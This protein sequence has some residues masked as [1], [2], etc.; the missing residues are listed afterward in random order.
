VPLLERAAAL[1]ET[2]PECCA[3]LGLALRQAGQ[4]EAAIAAYDRAIGRD[5]NYREALF[6]RATCRLLAGDFAQG[7]PDYRARES[8]AQA[9]PALHRAPLPADLA[10]KRVLVVPDQGIGDELF[11]LRL[12]PALQARGAA[13]SYIPDPRLHDMLARAG[14][15]RILPADAAR[16]GYDFTVAVGDLP[17]VLQATDTPPSIR[18]SALAEHEAALRAQLTAFGP[19]PWIGVTWRAGTR[20]RQNLLSKDSPAARTADA[21]RPLGARI[22]V[23]QR[24][25][26][27]GEVAAFSAALGRA[28]LDLSALNADLEAMLALVGLLDGQVCVSNT[29]VHLA[30]ARGRAC[31]VLVPNPPEFRWMQAGDASPWFPD[32]PV[33]RQLPDGSWDAAF[34]KLSDDLARF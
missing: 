33:Y 18:L 21:L 25:P 10:G 16:E 28:V 1:D 26:D 20:N 6:G 34:A 29:N 32:M 11:F 4:P 19:A 3:N 14:L 31:R 22:V 5:P 23:L 24:N 9:G 8:M 2:C 7:W 27:D 12:V 30:A 13:V 15:C 17:A